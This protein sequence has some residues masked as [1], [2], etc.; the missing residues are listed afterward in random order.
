MSIGRATRPVNRKGYED[1]VPSVFSTSKYL[2]TTAAHFALRPSYVAQH[3]YPEGRETPL[4]S[5]R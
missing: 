4:H 5:I 2:H 1:V 3:T